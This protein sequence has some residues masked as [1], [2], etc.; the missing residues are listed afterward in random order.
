MLLRIEDWKRIR[1][2]FTE[3]EKDELNAAII[4]EVLCPRGCM[5]DELKLT[6]ELSEKIHRALR[7]DLNAA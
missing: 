6:S 1:T 2:Q 7:S 5:I 4:G 3:V